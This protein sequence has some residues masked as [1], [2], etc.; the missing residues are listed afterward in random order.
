MDAKDVSAAVTGGASGL[1]EATARALADAGARVALL[2]LD[3]DAAKA[4]AADIGGVALRCDVTKAADAESAL[5]RAQE[6]IGALRILINCAGIGVAER[7][8]GRQGPMPLDHF[9]RVIDINL[10]GTFNTMRLA[11]AA[12]AELEPTASGERGVIVNTA[13]LAAYDGQIGQAAYSSSKGAVAALTLPAA[14]EFARSAIR[15]MTIAPGIFETPMF[16]GLPGPARESLL[17]MTLFPARLGRPEEF[18]KLVL[19][20]V[21]NAMLN[22]EVIRLDGGIRMPPR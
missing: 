19:H 4:V 2:D 11:A 8:V 22:G 15:V 12:M 5:E 7:I 10:N 13:S 3:G 21:D 17:G 20:I 9:T 1:G 6:A 14:R 16:S 18:A